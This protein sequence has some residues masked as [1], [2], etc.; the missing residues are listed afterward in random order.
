VQNGFRR[1]LHKRVE[2]DGADL[3]FARHGKCS[4]VWFI[5]CEK[6]RFN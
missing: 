2:P 4:I 6:V 3:L 1:D 5:D